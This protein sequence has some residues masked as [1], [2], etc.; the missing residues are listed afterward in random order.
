MELT[1]NSQDY[2]NKPA[3]GYMANALLSEP[4][5]KSIGDLQDVFVEKFRETIWPT[6]VD[7]LH[8]TLLDW[9]AP[10]VDYNHDKDVLFQAIL[11]EYDAALNEILSKMG[12]IDLTFDS[13]IVSPSAVAIIADEK[14]TQVFN[15]IRR[16][17]LAQVDLLPN[18]KQPPSIVHSTILR[19]T[20]EI[21]LE[22]I[23]KV[24]NSTD[25]SFSENVRAFQLVRETKLPMLEYSVIKK[26][27][28]FDM[29]NP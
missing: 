15:K 7:T 10:L 12:Y 24:A 11:P 27:F 1:I 19:F 3:I 4:S 9:L 17:F 23:K 8:I 21:P 5:R 28:L 26:Y 13:M 6:P 25:F 18:T 2:L 29:I 20:D 22:D 16:D 14:S